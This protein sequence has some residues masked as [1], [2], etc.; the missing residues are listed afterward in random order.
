MDQE[1]MIALLQKRFLLHALGA[2]VVFFWLAMMF[3]QVK[4]VQ[5]GTG[6]FGES[7]DLQTG[8]LESAERDWKEIYLKGKKIGYAVNLIKPFEEEYFIQEEI[9]LKLNLMGLANGVHTLTQSRV[10]RHFLLKSFFFSMRSGVVRFQMSGQVKGNRLEI[11]TGEEGEKRRQSI[12]LARPP[13]A[14]GGMEYFFRSRDLREGDSF[15]LPLF[16]PSTMAQ[17]EALVRVRGREPV[18]VN[19]RT[20]DAFRLETVLWGKP[21]TFWVDERGRALKEQGFMGMT[22]VRSSAAK[23]PEQMEGTGMDLYE[24]T[25][26][27]VDRP[28]PDPSRLHSLK[29]K[30]E[31]LGGSDYDS[32][33]LGTGR[34]RYEE[35]IL[36]IVRESPPATPAYRM[37]YVDDGKD[38]EA[39]LRAE[40]NIES[41]HEEIRNR[42]AQILAGERDP[43]VASRRLMEWVHEHLQK[44]PVLSLPSALEVLRTGLGDCNEHAVLLTALLRASGIPARLSIGLVY[45]RGKF[46]Y[47]AWTE[48]YLGKWITM[49]ATMNQMPTDVT[50]VKLIEGNL[51]QQARI[52]GLIGE[53][54]V[55]VLD[56]SRD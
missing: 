22:I 18:T 40:F 44:R 4:R 32:G 43:L 24:M 10:D 41:D 27:D 9:F 34:Q 53:L 35:G 8:V 14:G 21:M 28:L 13:M 12:P 49:D 47:H 46:F 25:A 16:D 31:G 7:A 29:L 2:A 20:Y 19:R 6:P 33:A 3:Y 51:D 37:P 54:K 30:V 55:E 36:E 11:E 48:A 23:A 17:T 42:A 38:M 1:E 50:H 39:F 15:C 52:A 45:T 56:Y 26:V 5:I